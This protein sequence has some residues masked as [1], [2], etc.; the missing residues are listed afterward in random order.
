MQAATANVEST[1]TADASGGAEDRIA[2]RVPLECQVAM[3]FENFDDFVT[4]CS[5]NISATG[6]FVRCSNPQPAGSVLDFKFALADGEKLIR[7]YGEVVWARNRD[8]G[9]ERPAGMGIRFLHLDAESRELIHWTVTRRYITGAGPCDVDAIKSAMQRAAEREALEEQDS[10][11]GTRALDTPARTRGESSGSRYLEAGYAA[12]ATAPRAH[13]KHLA[14]AIAVLA[15]GGSYLL[16]TGWTSADASP[17]AVEIATTES[18]TRVIEGVTERVPP[19]PLVSEAADDVAR[20]DDGTRPVPLAEPAIVDEPAALQ[21]AASRVASP[22]EI[23]K[24]WARAWSRQEVDNYLACY[25]TD[26]KPTGR[27]SRDDWEK[28]RAQRITKPRWIQIELGSFSTEVEG[29]SARVTFDQAYRSNSYRDVVRK[30]LVM[31]REPDGW[32]ILEEFT[33]S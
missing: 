21:P 28:Q 27:L 13:I 33:A 9:P 16:Q 18:V 12:V 20:S 4:E 32:R 31:V 19:E 25:A 7:G 30:T 29:D 2:N 17:A 14:P 3:R 6:M 11:A 8:D 26:F 23:V 24:N 10:L 1:V 22:N 5:M 15:L